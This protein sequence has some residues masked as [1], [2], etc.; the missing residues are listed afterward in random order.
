MLGTRDRST[1]GPPGDLLYAETT[2]DWYEMAGDGLILARRTNWATYTGLLATTLPVY[3]IGAAA[4]I[5]LGHANS[6]VA[7]LV[8]PML[9][10]LFVSYAAR[11]DGRAQRSAFDTDRV[12]YGV[13][14]CGGVATIA[15]SAIPL[16]ERSVELDGATRV[17]ELY[18]DWLAQQ[19]LTAQQREAFDVLRHEYEGSL[20]ELVETVK[21]LD[22]DGERDSSR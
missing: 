4:L 6:A 10:Y 1:L 22:G 13:A 5:L 7:L 19:G 14:A 20:G 21:N 12:G 16:L 2:L 3:Y 17:L 18:R 8:G 11:C 15:A 9:W